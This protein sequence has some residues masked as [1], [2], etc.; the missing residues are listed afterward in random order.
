[1]ALLTDPEAEA[2]A[3]RPVAVLL[4]P[5]GGT[6][7]RLG[8]AAAERIAAAFAARG[9]TAAV[10]PVAGAELSRSLQ[11]I[12]ARSEAERPAAIVVGGGDGTISLAAQELAGTGIPLGIIPL[13]T[14]NHFARDLG[15]PAGIEEAVAVIAAGHAV[16]VD[17]GEVNGRV[18]INN[19]SIG[20]YPEAVRERERQRRRTRRGKWLAMAI[21]L[22]RV[23]R[24]LPRHRLAITVGQSQQPRRTPFAFIG[25]NRY[26]LKPA[27]FGRR[28]CLTAGELCLFL[29]RPS[30]RLAIA[31]LLLRAALGRLDEAQ[32][33]E[34]FALRDFTIAC[35]RHRLRVALDGEV[36]AL[37]PP[38]R[39]RS[40]PGA[41]RVIAPP[42]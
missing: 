40:R 38:L 2:A 35:R 6:A 16:G 25:N 3:P 19:S 31:G 32:D 24:R 10:T 18:F 41:L 29:A 26:A 21:A 30:G 4:N 42:P 11:G 27:A 34:R 8:A 9:M 17:L 39:Y 1:M 37:R 33:F 28:S 7:A 36:A 15:L 20:L 14:L 12:L 22:L 23:L 13:G 5:H